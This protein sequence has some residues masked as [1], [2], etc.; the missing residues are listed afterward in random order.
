MVEEMFFVVDTNG[1]NGIA[2]ECS[3]KFDWMYLTDY[4]QQST[5]E[6]ASE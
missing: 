1:T 3:D 6:T 2:N 5:P 4:K